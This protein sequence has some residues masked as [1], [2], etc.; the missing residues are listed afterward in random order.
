MEQAGEKPKGNI[1]KLIKDATVFYTTVFF[2]LT[3]IFRQGL[4]QKASALM[5]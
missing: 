3:A 4:L 2:S 1:V 5:Q